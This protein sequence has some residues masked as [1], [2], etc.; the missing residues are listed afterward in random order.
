MIS[1][2]IEIAA[3][4]CLLVDRTV[5]SLFINYIIKAITNENQRRTVGVKSISMQAIIPE[6]VRYYCMP[7]QAV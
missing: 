2:T 4:N 7:E 1:N 6:D 5:T 3:H